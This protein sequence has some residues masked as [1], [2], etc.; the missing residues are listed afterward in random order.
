MGDSSDEER[1]GLDGGEGVDHASLL[2]EELSAATLEA[3]QSHLAA[4]QA[5]ASESSDD[6]AFDGAKGGAGVSEDFGMSQ[7]WV[8]AGGPSQ[9]PTPP[10]ECTTTA[11]LLAGS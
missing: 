9:P 1:G 8:R 6:E 3:L 10:P 4:K 2:Q 7:F 5:H 11:P